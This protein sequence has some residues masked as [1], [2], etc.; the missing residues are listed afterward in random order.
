MTPNELKRLDSLLGSL[1]GS[2]MKWLDISNM[3]NFFHWCNQLIIDTAYDKKEKHLIKMIKESKSQDD[4]NK[5]RIEKKNYLPKKHPKKIDVGDIV[6]IDFGYGYCSE[7]SDG[8][9]GIVLSNF[10]ANMYFVI[11]CSSEPLKL[12]PYPI[13]LG[14]PNKEHNP[15]KISYLRFDQMRMIHYRRMK[16]VPDGRDHNVGVETVKNIKKNIIQFLD[17][18]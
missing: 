1:K 15:D 12:F 2:A 8:H 10:K 4:I 9:Y 3:D 6:Y 14:V 18:S 5:M 13:K 16:I 11:P 7:L 17:L